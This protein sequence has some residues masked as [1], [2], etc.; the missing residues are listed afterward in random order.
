[1]PRDG[2]VLNVRKVTSQRKSRDF[3]LSAIFSPL[4]NIEQQQQPNMPAKKKGYGSRKMSKEDEDG[5][6]NIQ[7]HDDTS[8]KA[9]QQGQTANGAAQGKELISPKAKCVC[10]T[11][12]LCR[13]SGDKRTHILSE[14]YYDDSDIEGD[15]ET[16][17]Q[18]IFSKQVRKNLNNDDPMDT[19]SQGKRK[20]IYS[21]KVI[22]L[23]DDDGE[24]ADTGATCSKDDR[25]VY[26]LFNYNDICWVMNGLFVKIVF[27]SGT[28]KTSAGSMARPSG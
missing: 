17:G 1:M 14:D 10:P 23:L 4:I 5:V 21:M 16:R 22:R 11:I 13:M 9:D 3:F 26:L 18:C 8:M 15:P 7:E 6:G 28:R 12:S 20:A 2:S 25:F 24:P 19:P 27:L